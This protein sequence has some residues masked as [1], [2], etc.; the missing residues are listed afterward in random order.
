MRIRTL[1]TLGLSSWAAGL[2]A[3]PAILKLPAE[4][5]IERPDQDSEVIHQRARK[6]GPSGEPL[7]Y[8]ELTQVEL[9][10][11]EHP[12]PKHLLEE[13]RKQAQLSLSIEGW[14]GECSRPKEGALGKLQSFE[15]T[16]KLSG[17]SINGFTQTWVAAVSEH[18]AYTLSYAGPQNGYEQVLPQIQILRGTDSFPRD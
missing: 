2:A 17:S 8:I 6:I 15:T 4:W 13:M 14:L 1:L 9:E 10:E 5:V 16:C 3:Q 7:M 11:G 18:H 12:Q